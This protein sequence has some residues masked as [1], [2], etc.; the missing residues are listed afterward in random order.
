MQKEE[1][2]RR[3]RKRT[4]ERKK[5]IGKEKKTEKI[6]SRIQTQHR[7][8]LLYVC[9][10]EEKRNRCPFLRFLIT[11]RVLE[12]ASILNLMLTSLIVTW[13]VF[14]RSK[15]D[16]KLSSRAFFFRILDVFANSEASHFSIR[17]SNHSSCLFPSMFPSL[18][19]LS[20]SRKKNKIK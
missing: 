12:F 20:L 17:A 19:F 9:T 3:K 13:L 1:R 11:P 7:W 2:S 5:E 15:N 16:T 4:K 6:T 18:L 14:S 8:F 10:L